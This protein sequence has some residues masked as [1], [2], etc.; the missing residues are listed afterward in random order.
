ML[1]SLLIFIAVFV[2][3]FY[4]FLTWNFNYWKKRGIKS[5]KPQPFV[6]NFPSV[7][8]QKR[9][10]AIDIKEIYEYVVIRNKNNLQI[11]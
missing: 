6:G 9:H 10:I 3:L 7:F 4:V 8:T 5:P 11:L 2:I 1:F